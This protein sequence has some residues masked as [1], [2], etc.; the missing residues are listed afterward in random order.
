MS[1]KF[2]LIDAGIVVLVIN[3]CFMVT[4]ASCVLLTQFDRIISSDYTPGLH[5]KLPFIHGAAAPTHVWPTCIMR[6]V[7]LRLRA[8]RL[9]RLGP[10]S[11]IP[12]ICDV[13]PFLRPA[14]AGVIH[15]IPE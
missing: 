2:A 13:F 5:F 15:V 7:W 10:P 4:S 1:H 3:A 14:V 11:K 8:L 9:P 12:L 6:R